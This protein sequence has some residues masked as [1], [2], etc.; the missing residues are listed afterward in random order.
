VSRARFVI[1]F[2]VVL[3]PLAALGSLAWAGNRDVGVLPAHAQIAN[4]DVGGLSREDAIT[5]LRQV[6]G[7]PAARD[8]TVQVGD[9]T[10]RLSADKAGVTLDLPA[11]VGRAYDAT[12]QGNMLQR[13]W[14]RLTG[15]K[16]VVDETVHVTA[17][18]AAVQ[19][20]VGSIHAAVA[21]KAAN[22]TIAM[23]VRSV[24]VTQAKPGARLSGRED[25]VARIIAALQH[26]NGVRG[27][28]AHVATVAPQVGDSDLWGATPVALT[29]SKHDKLVRVFDRG[30]LIK[31]YHVAV[32]M[33][34]YPTPDGQFAVQSV[35]KNPV[36]TV[37]NSDW[38]GALAGKVIPGGS[39]QNP[40][41]A[42]FIRF[43]GSVGMHGTAELGS[44]GTAASH[45]C[46]RMNPKDVTDLATRVTVG[47]PVLVGT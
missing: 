18:R 12:H 21:H 13:G 17:S 46:V 37:P 43:D 40:L 33:P 16:T 28:S 2:L 36:W 8:V 20:F 34:K 31:T 44:L 42:Y 6:I 41:K 9:R 47:T 7:R 22:A 27:F 39:P 29:V 15:E 4:V 11:A 30:K 25:L 3:V 35:E 19:S 38:A 32:G 26:P 24:S 14:R 10:F 5:R 23:T 1:G 45:G